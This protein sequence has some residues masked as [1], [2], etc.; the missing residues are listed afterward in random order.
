[1]KNERVQVPLHP[2]SAMHANV[3]DLTGWGANTEL[4]L[5]TL[6]LVLLMCSDLAAIIQVNGGD[7]F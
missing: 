4:I 5:A 3:T 2:A 6:Q 7:R 1:M